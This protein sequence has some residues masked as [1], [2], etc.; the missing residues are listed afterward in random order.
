MITHEQLLSAIVYDQ[1][2]GEFVWRHRDDKPNNWNGR[3]AGT[4]AGSISSHGYWQ[5]GIDHGVYL[6]HRLAILY[7]T[8]EWPPDQVDHIDGDRCNNAWANLRLASSRQNHCN[9]GARSYNQLGIKGVRYRHDRG[10][11][12]AAIC[13]EGNIR[14]L[15]RYATA[16]EA[17]EAYCKAGEELHGEFF[18]E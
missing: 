16:E 8:G 18:H 1:E 13:Y 5:I 4:V 10:L 9:T 15:G 3:F 6:A 17:H 11:Y 2:T 7:M 14:Y 12:E